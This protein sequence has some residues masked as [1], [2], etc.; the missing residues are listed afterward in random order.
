MGRWITPDPLNYFDPLKRYIGEFSSPNV[1]EAYNYAGDNPLRY[2]DPLGLYR[3]SNDCRVSQKFYNAAAI[4][5]G[6]IIDTGCQNF[7]KTT[8]SV[9]QS[10]FSKLLS[11]NTLPDVK[12]VDLQKQTDVPGDYSN[13][14]AIY[15][16]VT[17]NLYTGQVTW[18]E[19]FR[20]QIWLD[21]RLEGNAYN[22][23]HIARTIL[24]ELAHY[25]DAIYQ[26]TKYRRSLIL[27]LVLYRDIGEACEGKCF[28]K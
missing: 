6:K 8:L 4:I 27:D 15:P 25:A 3:I 24:H 18:V 19:K 28:G 12:M 9:N 17:V 16:G 2:S 1:S 26:N 23:E 22:A 14:L 13:A 7:F 10:E 20:H 5:G 11:A 21:K